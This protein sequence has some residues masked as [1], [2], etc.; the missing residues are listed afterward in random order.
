[1]E[2]QETLVPHRRSVL[3]SGDEP[4]G[5]RTTTNGPQISAVRTLGGAVK[6]PQ[7][8]AYLME[9]QGCKELPAL[10]WA[11]RPSGTGREAKC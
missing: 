9:L 10:P 8:H 3:G 11:S 4:T 6:L 2:E 1:M 5:L 7:P